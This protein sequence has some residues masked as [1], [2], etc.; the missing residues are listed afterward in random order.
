MIHKALYL[1]YIKT[2]FQYTSFSSAQAIVL[3]T[4]DLGVLEVCGVYSRLRCV[5]TNIGG[6]V[7]L[8]TLNFI[9]KLQSSSEVSIAW[10][11]KH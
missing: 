5:L 4:A 8:C 7:V 10:A 1:F 6:F 2:G 9:S 11:A 3:I